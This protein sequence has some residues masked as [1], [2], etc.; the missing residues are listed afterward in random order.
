MPIQNLTGDPA[1]QYLAD[2]L[3]EVLIAHLARLPGLAVAS[4]ATMA[5][6]RG[7]G[8]DELA[9]AEKLGVRL[10][11]A[12]SVVQADDRIALSVKLTDPR[13]GRT[14]WGSEL[15]RQPS[16]ILDARSEIA[17]L[18]AARLLASRSGRAPCGRLATARRRSARCVLARPRRGERRFCDQRAGSDRLVLARRAARTDMGRSAGAPGAG[19]ATRD[20]I[21]RSGTSSIAGAG[22]QGQRHARHRARS[23]GANELHG[24]G[25]DAGVP[26][27]GF[28]RGRSHPAPGDRHLTR[29]CFRTRASRA[30]C[31][32][33]PD[34]W[35]R[36][37][38]EA[39]A[40]RDR[41]PL[42]PERHTNLG[43]VRYYARDFNAALA[44]MD[45]GACD[46]SEL[47]AGPSR[48][49]PRACSARP[50]TTKRS[51]ASRRR[52]RSVTTPAGGQRSASPM[53]RPAGMTRARI[54][55][56]EAARVRA[57][58]NFCQRRPIRVYCSAPGTAG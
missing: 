16:T 10:L 25:G 32:P 51:T 8:G 9:L 45:A 17:R 46:F 26:R 3:T 14:I 34:G 43:M 19:R 18:V 39:R 58:R 36:P 44:E 35:T 27:L 29:R 33:P 50:A 5:T 20:R 52:S 11:L 49:R 47:R 30:R 56:S 41:E 31:W 7:A 13:E 28:R 6:L 57:A 37:S 22:R 4:S 24:A 12:G 2:G 21:R 15:E 48:P 23:V 55:A 40:A 42:V 1:K 53:P 54:S 38:R